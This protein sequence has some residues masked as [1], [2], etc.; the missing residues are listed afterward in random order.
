M[1]I[2][3]LDFRVSLDVDPEFESALD[4]ARKSKRMTKAGYVRDTLVND[5]IAKGFLKPSVMG[6][7]R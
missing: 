6:D 4:A 1:N 7:A 5:L 3:K 2:K